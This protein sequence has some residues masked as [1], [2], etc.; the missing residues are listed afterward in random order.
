MVHKMVLAD[1]YRD[2]IFNKDRVTHHLFLQ[3]NTCTPDTL[4]GY[5]PI[6]QV[7]PKTSIRIIYHWYLT[8]QQNLAK[9]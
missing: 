6:F 2:H 9:G 1:T 4:I 5:L 8:D 7:L 3:L